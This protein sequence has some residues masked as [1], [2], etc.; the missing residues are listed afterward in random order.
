MMGA[1][2]KVS[3]DAIIEALREHGSRRAAARPAALGGRSALAR[4]AS[5]TSKGWRMVL[6]AEFP[7][8]V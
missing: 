6:P 3:D 2:Q 5:R 1:P 7:A 4:S 8:R